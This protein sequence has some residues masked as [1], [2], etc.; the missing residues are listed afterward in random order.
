MR[1]LGWGGLILLIVSMFAMVQR[2]TLLEFAIASVLSNYDVTDA[3][4]KVTR[5]DVDGIR[6]DDIQLANQV[7]AKSVAVSYSISGLTQGHVER[8]NVAGLAVD[9]SA[10]ETGVLGN[11][12]TV[13]ASNGTSSS[14]PMVQLPK[15]QITNAK[16]YGARNDAMFTAHINGDLNGDLSAA[17]DVKGHGLLTTSGRTFK[18]EGVHAGVV[19]AAGLEDITVTLQQGSVAD[20]SPSPWFRPLKASGTVHYGKGRLALNTVISAIDDRRLL[21]VTG[22]HVFDKNSG[23][24]NLHLQPIVL[25]SEGLRPEDLSPLL[26]DFRN[27][28][29]QINGNANVSWRH[30]A[31]QGK[32]NA[33]L[34]SI[35]F[36]KN[37]VAVKNLNTAIDFTTLENIDRAQLN[38]ANGRATIANK[39]QTLKVSNIDGSVTGAI[40]Q[41]D[42][43]LTKAVLRDG[44]QIPRFV[45]VD[46]KGMGK[47]NGSELAF[48]INAEALGG[49]IRLSAKGVHHVVN[50][51]GGA[52]I[53]LS[54]LNFGRGALQPGDLFPTVKVPG[55]VS[56]DIVARADIVWDGD[57]VDGKA[58]GTI[59]GAS[60]TSGDIGIRQASAELSIPSL[61]PGAPISIGLTKAG[62]SFDVANSYFKVHD[63]SAEIMADQQSGHVRMRL[64]SATLA[65]QNATPMVKPAALTGR[66][67]VRGEQLTFEATASIL[68]AGKGRGRV[69]VK[70]RHHLASKAG[71]ASFTVAPIVFDPLGMTPGD[72]LAVLDPIKHASGTV[73]GKG[74]IYWAANKFDGTADLSADGLSFT[75]NTTKVD[76]L[77]GTLHFDHLNPLNTDTLQQI[78]AAGI[79]DA[80]SVSKPF[81]RFRVENGQ[82]IYIDHAEVGIAGGLVSVDGV[83]VDDSRAPKRLTLKLSDLDLEKFM[84]LLSVDG[85]SGSGVINGTV[86]VEIK[87]NVVLVQDG[88]LEAAGP[89]V[90]RFRS[91][92]A[93]HAL[94]GGGEQ[95][96]L[97]LQVLEDFHYQRLSL[98]LGRAEAAKADIRLRV[99]GANPAVKDGYPFILNITLSGNLDNALAAVVETLRLSD[100]ALKSA[101]GVGSP[102]N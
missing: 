50:G 99:E 56:G 80:I 19:V 69:L 57:D 48:D 2:N 58:K 82:Q 77:N 13:I 86:P 42:L 75:V 89:G 22:H 88:L 21:R 30:G 70:G 35:S 96:A 102:Q 55:Q 24:A 25:S 67:D 1:F 98:R 34:S 27:V 17:F 29:G 83:V 52:K 7:T 73:G 72:I 100:R 28:S 65:D 32:G 5:F 8:V 39:G 59:S 91:E 44:G 90:L 64:N 10:P 18:A 53:S 3:G 15:I 12:M 87:H 47:L 68:P 23:V 101:A 37:E 60:Y 46:L 97:L 11:V 76:H 14:A 40:D 95:V 79:A 51:K 78:S 33:L 63:V 81:V 85:V 41:M 36:E 4:F 43:Q 6:I 16:I 26:A 62:A 74:H 66:A 31:V 9:V 49:E 94:A 93:R 84:A 61:K 38:I 20:L 71:E 92:Q 45:P 54:P